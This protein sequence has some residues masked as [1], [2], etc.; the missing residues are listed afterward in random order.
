MQ[1]CVFPACTD[2]D[3]SYN[4]FRACDRC[5]I[6]P[7]QYDAHVLRYHE[8]LQDTLAKF[9]NVMPMFMIRKH[10]MSRVK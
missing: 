1:P 6:T 3:T 10:A 4:A 5:L 8:L 7:R 9:G 2:G